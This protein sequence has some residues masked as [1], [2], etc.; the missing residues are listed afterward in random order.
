MGGRRWERSTE[1][2]RESRVGVGTG[3]TKNN[4][5]KEI[6]SNRNMEG[7]RELKPK[8]DVLARPEETAQALPSAAP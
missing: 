4:R 3:G 8:E 5:I 1:G 2:K 6:L 7:G